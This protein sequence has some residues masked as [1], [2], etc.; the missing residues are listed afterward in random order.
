MH[1]D[2][3]KDKATTGCRILSAS[4]LK[5]VWGKLYPNLSVF[6]RALLLPRCFVAM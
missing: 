4:D 5:N 1:E 6:P 2:S 3:V